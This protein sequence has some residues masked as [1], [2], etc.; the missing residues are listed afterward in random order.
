MIGMGAPILLGEEGGL[1]GLRPFV[2]Y[3]F[4]T[5]GRF[6]AVA[7][8]LDV[9]TPVGALG[10]ERPIGML[11]VILTKAFGTTRIHYNAGTSIGSA[12]G[13]LED[14]PP[15]GSASLGLDHT[16]WRQSAVIMAD[17][18]RNKVS[19]ESWWLVGA[20]IR[21]QA[22]PTMVFDVGMQRRLSP[23]GPDL[24]LTAGITKSFALGGGVE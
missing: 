24:V 22:T 8:R 2:F 1:A 6:P 9:T 12:N 20:G 14:H 4:N 11:T 23:V 10:G 16:L 7:V 19:G 18:Q 3:N 17:I 15:H 21:M 13:P 5:E